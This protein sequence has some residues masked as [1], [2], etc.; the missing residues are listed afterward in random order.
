MTE[1][2]WELLLDDHILARSTG[3]DRVIHHPRARGVALPADKPWESSGIQPLYVERRADGSFILFYNAM[4]WDIDRAGEIKSQSMRNDRPHQVFSAIGMAT[5]EDGIHWTKPNLGL[6]D[7]PAAVDRKRN[8]PFPSPVGTTRENNLGVPFIIA[9]D[10]AR[11]GNVSDPEKRYAVRTSPEYLRA[12]HV[13]SQEIPESSRGYFAREIPDFLHDPD[14]K[15]KLQDSGGDFNPRRHSL[16]Y[17]DDQHSEWVTL[18]QGVAP[19]WLPSRE[20]AR[21]ASKD[22]KSWTSSAVIYPDAAD[23]HDL[24]CYDEP[25]M[26]LPWCQEGLVFGLLGWF[27]SD[28]THADSMPNLV[29]TPEH[30]NVWPWARKGTCEIRITIS[31][32]GGHTWDRTSSREAFIPHGT[33]A[34]AYDRLLVWGPPPVRVDDEDWFYIYAANQDHLN[35]LNTPGQETYHHSGPRVAHVLLYTQKHNRYVSMRARSR[36]ENLITKGVQVNGGTLQLN[37]DADHGAV[38]VGIASA[39]PVPTFNG[40]VPSEAPHLR[41]KHMLPGFTFEDC[42]PIFANSTEHVVRF[43]TANVASLRGKSVCLLF[44]MTDADLYGFRFV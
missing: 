38:R 33:E 26:M 37:I 7:A 1:P 4:W 9:Q 11:H 34:D 32:D 8:A 35:T 39:D 22:L 25:M 28:R 31:R 40:T 41:L 21:F 14:W 19:H 12:F 42:E 3:F 18:D 44:E 13:A 43:K 17:W 24:E 6:I 5:S 36:G 30:P 2:H 29:S 10:L 15:S 20:I 27:H 16:H 23:P